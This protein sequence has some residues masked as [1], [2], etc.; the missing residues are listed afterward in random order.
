MAEIIF[1]TRKVVGFTSL[2][3]GADQLF[4]ETVLAYGRK[5]VS[6]IPVHHNVEQLVGVEERRFKALRNR[7]SRVIRVAGR[8]A[9]D[10]FLRAGQRVCDSVDRMIFVWDG[11]P[12]L[13]PGGTADIVAY[14]RK[15][16]R[17]GVILDPIDKRVRNLSSVE[18]RD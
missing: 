11:G 18:G 8:S 5:L 16:E 7:S 12:P 1:E 17:D 4:A 9:D 15:M 13:G 2:A 14:A 3:V 6:V 10:A